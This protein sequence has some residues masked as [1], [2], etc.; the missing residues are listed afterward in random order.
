MNVSVR[1][2]DK[3]TGVDVRVT[4]SAN[5]P[6]GNPEVATLIT[7]AAEHVGSIAQMQA[8]KYAKE[9]KEEEEY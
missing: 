3:F 9:M 6:L 2:E 5:S 7:M 8:D 1:A 4:I